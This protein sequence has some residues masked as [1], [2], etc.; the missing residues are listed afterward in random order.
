MT[1]TLLD[2]VACITAGALPGRWEL[3]GHDSAGS[4]DTCQYVLD[5]KHFRAGSSI[6]DA[7]AELAQG[8]DHAEGRP[9]ARHGHRGPR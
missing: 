3:S 4:A 2:G 5:R 7:V 9:V 1:A 8:A 6:T